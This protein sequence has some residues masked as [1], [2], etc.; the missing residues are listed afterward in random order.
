MTYLIIGI[1]SFIFG[2]FAGIFTMALCRAVKQNDREKR[3][4]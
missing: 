4:E 3:G 1:L 2:A